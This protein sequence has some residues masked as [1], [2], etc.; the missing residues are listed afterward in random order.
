MP[1]PLAICTFALIL[2]VTTPAAAQQ[3]TPEPLGPNLPHLAAPSPTELLNQLLS[4]DAAIRVKA[5]TLVAVAPLFLMTRTPGGGDDWT[6]PSEARLFFGHY[7]NDNDM[8]VVAVNIHQYTWASVLLRGASGWER[9]GRFVCWC[10]YESNPMEGFIELRPVL[11]WPQ[12]EILVHDSGGG[13]G[14]YTRNLSVYRI[15]NSRLEQ[16]FD[17]EDKRVDG[18]PTQNTDY[19]TLTETRIDYRTLD[20]T[21]ALAV[22][23]LESIEPWVPP[24]ASKGIYPPP[25][26]VYKS[27]RRIGCE[28]LLWDNGK[29]AFVRSRKWTAS[30]CGQPPPSGHATQK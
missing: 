15:R 14:L 3:P 25:L 12:T 10:R 1:Y 13:S 17:T 7:Q 9:I 20:N 2:L 11:H 5:L 27:V 30:Y 19:G 21:S 24:D 29:A 26:E 23:R 22:V 8:A 6:V 16:I 28:V 18:H 4:P